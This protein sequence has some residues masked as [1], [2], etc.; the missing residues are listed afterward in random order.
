MKEKCL[1]E[2]KSFRTFAAGNNSNRTVRFLVAPLKVALVNSSKIAD[3]RG[4]FSVPHFY[5]IEQNEES[6]EP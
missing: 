1:P 5:S 6:E 2:P 4:V 3:F